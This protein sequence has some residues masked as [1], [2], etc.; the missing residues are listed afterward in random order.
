MVKYFSIQDDALIKTQNLSDAFWT[1]LENPDD[2]ELLLHSTQLNIDLDDLKSALDINEISRVEF[3]DDHIFF[4]LKV[5][6]YLKTKEIKFYT[7]PIGF[8]IFS[9]RVLSVCLSNNNVLSYFM[10]VNKS[11]SLQ[12]PYTFIISILNRTASQYL[13]MLTEINKRTS[14]IEKELQ[15]SMKNKELIRLLNLEKSLVY[16]TTS[17]RS[18]EMIT[19]KLKR[20]K[21]YSQDEDLLDSLDD[22]LVEVKQAIEM[23]DIYSN[24]L[25]GMMGAFASIISNNLSVIMK[26]MTMITIILQIP[27]LISSFGGMN[28][29]LPLQSY[30]HAYMI[31]ALLSL[32]LV[33]IMIIIFHYKKYL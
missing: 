5:P 1:Y 21:A 30:P 23:S 26:F 4:I 9:D 28:Y 20:A 16:F 10:G 31:M 25:S 27:T 13:K 12:S 7:E 14:Y 18:N 22:V 19:R 32:L 3:N 2:D 17:L 33:V 11:T 8:F 29:K 24:I 15:E 6:L